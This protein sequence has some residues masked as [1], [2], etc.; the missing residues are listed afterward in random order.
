MKKTLYF[1]IFALMVLCGTMNC[2]AEDDGYIIH[3][4]STFEDYNDGDVPGVFVWHTYR[5]DDFDLENNMLEDGRSNT[6]IVKAK[7]NDGSENLAVKFVA[8]I[9]DDQFGVARALFNHYPMKDKGVISFSVMVDDY[10]DSGKVAEICY[11]VTSKNHVT[12]ADNQVWP[13]L[14]IKDNDVYFDPAGVANQQNAV[15]KEN[16]SV[17]VWYR[18]D[19][20]FDLKKSKV[21]I[22]FDGKPAVFNLPEAMVNISGVRYRLPKVADSSWYIDDLRIYEADDVVEDSVLDA[23]WKKYTDSSF[24]FGQEFEANRQTNYDYMAFLKCDGKKLAVIN[25]NKFFNGSEVVVIPAPIYYKDDTLM[26]PVR[27]LA[28]E[29]GA[30][31]GWDESTEKVSVTFGGKTMVITPDNAEYYVNGKL[32]KLP[33]PAE[34]VSGSACIP[35]KVLFNF[36]DQ[37]YSLQKDIL[38]IDQPAEFDWHMPTDVAG[39]EL[40]G[41]NRLSPDENVYNRILRTL[42]YTRPSDDDIKDAINKSH[43]RIEFTDSSIAEIKLKMETDTR[44]KAAVNRLLASVPDSVVID[45]TTTNPVN[46]EGWGLYDG[47]RTN[48]TDPLYTY[49]NSVGFAYLMSDD[50]TKAKYKAE[51]WKYIERLNAMPTFHIEYNSGLGTGTLAYGLAYAY[52]WIDWSEEERAVIENMCKRNILDHALH[53]YTCTLDEWHHSICY[54]EGNQ[55]LITNGGILMLAT[56]LYDETD[57][58]YYLKIIRGALR[59]TEGGTV[60]YFPDGEYNEGISYWEYAG[61]FLPR[62]IKGLQTAMDTDWGISDVPGVLKTAQFPFMMKGATRAYAYGDAQPTDAIISMLMFGA[63]QTD[64]KALAEYRK[65]NLTYLDSVDIANWVYD[66]ENYDYGLELYDLDIHNKRNSTVVMKTGWNQN[67]TTVAFHAGG[68]NDPHGHM[69]I[70]SVQFDMEGVRFGMDL[71]REDYN[72]RDKGAYN[73]QDAPADYAFTANHYYRQK[74]EGHNTVVA[75]RSAI[76]QKISTDAY[77]YDMIPTAKSQFT[78]MKFGE[79]MSYAVLNMTQTND[80]YDC[81]IRGV[82]LDKDKNVIYIQDDFAALSETDFLW[83]MHTKAQ[84]EISADGKSAILTSGNSK[85]KA[86]ILNNCDFVFEELAASFDI[87][88]G[89]NLKP[90]VETANNGIHKLAVRTSPGQNI[91]RFRLDVA[92]QPYDSTEVAEYT[93]IE[94]WGNETFVKN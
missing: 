73:V 56:A 28:E 1:M 72:L 19:L 70:G 46:D 91:R 7:K 80:I 59:A 12:Y 9:D 78:E 8:D 87:A 16:I 29:L 88:Y 36:L 11:N 23:A 54:G 3:K 21:T 17:G 34:T 82:K 71:D 66:T 94:T 58:E 61:D 86:T 6:M 84:I 69:D 75:N 18:I 42:L 33:Y 65:N 26:V 49:F 37:D 50:E 40:S 79:D 74:G 93:P 47:V 57:S 5:G 63:S 90:P 24:Y 10:A 68:N 39:N 38:W 62:V 41:T 76:N 43:P 48:Y 31:V 81:A 22:Y 64:N 85:I 92:F 53:A 60:T 83:S 2:S 30:T 25:T 32:A 20:V 51:V 45:K 44:L 14:K 77:S 27:A 15:I 13:I 67:D 55:A 89:T 4:N 52:D 35:L